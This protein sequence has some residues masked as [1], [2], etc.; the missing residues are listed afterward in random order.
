[1]LTLAKDLFDLRSVLQKKHIVIAYSGYLNEQVLGGVGDAIKHKLSIENA[2][3]KT[4]RNVFAIFVEQM[5]NMIRYSA[6]K[7]PPD[8]DGPLE[9]RYG[10]LTISDE[11]GQYVIHAGNLIAQAD[12]ERL[13][14]RLSEIRAMDKDELKALY[15]AK[16]KAPVEEGSKGAGV[17]MIEIARRASKPIDFDFMELDSDY[18][19]FALRACV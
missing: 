12:V 18:V 5:Q 14:K 2:D 13:R 7:S 3:T 8:S 16:L 10:V 15:K 17:G 1:M 6:E 4:I 9:L 19:F 11:D